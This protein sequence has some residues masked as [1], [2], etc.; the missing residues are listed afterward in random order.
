MKKIRIGVLGANRGLNIA[1]NFRLLGCEIVALCE[2][3]E[4]RARKGLEIYGEDL[5]VYKDFDE[6]LQL[7]LDAVIIANFFHEHTPFAI[8]CFEKSAEGDLRKASEKTDGS[9]LFT[10]KLL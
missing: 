7:D 2:I 1:E 10:A 8:K 3:D 4:K 9:L 6:F 5:P